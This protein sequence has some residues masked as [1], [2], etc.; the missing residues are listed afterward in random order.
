M[1][2]TLSADIH[3][4]RALIF[5]DLWKPSFETAAELFWSTGSLQ[6]CCLLSPTTPRVKATTAPTAKTDAA[7]EL[8]IPTSDWRLTIRH[9]QTDWHYVS[10]KVQA[11][12]RSSSAICTVQYN[13]LLV[14]NARGGRS[15][16]DW[17]LKGRAGRCSV[18]KTS[19]RD[20]FAKCNLNS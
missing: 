3:H 16:A 17:V 10:E 9:A 8:L 11:P 12:N 15:S 7:R 18:I 4:L 5:N 13:N 1:L 19:L 2:S 6:A 14:D 20:R